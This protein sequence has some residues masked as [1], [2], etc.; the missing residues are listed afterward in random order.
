MSVR[1]M[2]LVGNARLKSTEP[3]AREP[4]YVFEEARHDFA[5][6]VKVHKAIGWTSH[7]MFKNA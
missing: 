5:H 1:A 2:L 7:P 3:S 6:I 4:D